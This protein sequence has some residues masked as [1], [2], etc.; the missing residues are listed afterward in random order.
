MQGVI[1]MVSKWGTSPWLALLLAL[2]WFAVPELGGQAMAGG[3][4]PPVDGTVPPTLPGT[5]ASL[6]GAMVTAL[7][8]IG[9]SVGVLSASA[10]FNRWRRQ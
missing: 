7:S 9:A 4:V 10:W 5:G 6:A 2:A 1:G 3:T 8:V